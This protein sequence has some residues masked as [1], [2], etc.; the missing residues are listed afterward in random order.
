MCDSAVKKALPADKLQQLWKSLNSQ[1]GAYKEI[2]QTSENSLPMGSSIVLTTKFE[3]MFLDITVTFDKSN[4][5]AGFFLA[6]NNKMAEYN[7]PP[8]VS[9]LS[10]IEKEVT[11]GDDEW[12][13]PGTL[14]VPKGNPPF[15]AVILVHGSGPNDRDESIGPNKPFRDLAWG[16]ASK[17]IAVLRYEKRTKEHGGKMSGNILKTLTL[18]EETIDDALRAVKTLHI[19]PEIDSKKIFILGHSLGAMAIPRIG[20]RDES[21]AGFIVMAGTVRPLEDVIFD[22]YNYIFSLD[23]N[24]SD[25]EQ[26]E[27]DTLKLQIQN[28]KSP[29]LTPETPAAELPLSQPA[30]Y[31]LD[32]RGYNP[33]LTAKAIK[34]PVYVL[35][36]KRDYQVTELEFDLWKKGLADRKNF[37][38]KLYPKLNHLFMEG[39]GKSA[40]EEYMKEGHVADYVIQDIATWI[41]DNIK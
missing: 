15:P 24:I 39:D 10:F 34:K 17:G 4:K 35:Q 6:P 3:K 13:L 27:L 14:T 37:L 20:I 9:M 38:F 21:V 1:V 33:S 25:E 22:Q 36:G 26:K 28:V 19:Q 16:L 32:L 7:A 2:V 29:K 30:A 12:K 11:I 31:W 23:G 18:K 8:Y 40:P 5:V 41:K